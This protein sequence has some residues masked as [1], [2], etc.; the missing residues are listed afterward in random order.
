M[1]RSL[2]TLNNITKGFYS[3]SFSTRNRKNVEGLFTIH[4]Q[5][6][7]TKT[8]LAIEH[9]GSCVFNIELMCWI[10]EHRHANEL[11]FDSFSDQPDRLIV[12]KYAASPLQRQA[13][14]P[15]TDPIFTQTHR[16]FW[17]EHLDWKQNKIPKS[18]PLATYNKLVGAICS[19]HMLYV[20]CRRV[21]RPHMTV[22]VGLIKY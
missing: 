8:K 4:V 19:K 20:W 18:A 3:Q 11:I 6:S 17:R 16:F 5:K 15:L 12:S 7:R 2:T 13:F 22:S 1:F 10:S 14:L 21:R 9:N